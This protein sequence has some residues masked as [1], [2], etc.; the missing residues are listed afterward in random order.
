MAV[1]AAQLPTHQCDVER[2]FL[3][4][5]GHLERDVFE[6]DGLPAGGREKWLDG[7]GCLVLA[8]RAGRRV[9]A[10]LAAALSKR[11]HGE[12]CARGRKS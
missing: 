9:V 2:R 3:A 12:G 11:G 6:G 7:R 5:V 10:I 4:I 8:H 1:V